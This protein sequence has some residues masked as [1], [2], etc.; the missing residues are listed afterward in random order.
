MTR[1]RFAVFCFGVWILLIQLPVCVQAEDP[2]S[3]F[4]LSAVLMDAES[5]RVL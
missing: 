4:S 3:L 5:G 1:K 2:G